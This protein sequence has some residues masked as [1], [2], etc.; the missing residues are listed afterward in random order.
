MFGFFG[1]RVRRSSSL[2]EFAVVLRC[3]DSSEFAG[4]RILRV[5]PVVIEQSG[6]PSGF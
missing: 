2:F 3:S 4:V 1:V 5:M 6:G